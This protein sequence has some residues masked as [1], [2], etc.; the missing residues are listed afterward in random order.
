MAWDPKVSE[1]C[2]LSKSR[3]LP[4]MSPHHAYVV[5]FDQGSTSSSK[6]IYNYILLKKNNLTL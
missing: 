6:A 2:D 3:D 5:L 1:P 4:M